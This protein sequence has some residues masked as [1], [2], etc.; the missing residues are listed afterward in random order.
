MAPLR[1][2]T[3]K[4][5]AQ[6]EARLAF[7][8]STP[9]KGFDRSRVKGLVARLVTV[10]A[11]SASSA[12]EIT[13]GAKLYQVVVDNET[14]GKLLLEKGKLRKRV[15][16]LPLNKLNSRVTDPSRVSK[17]KE[18][19]AAKGG[20][21][22]LALEL[23]GYDDEVLKAV[24][25]CFGATIICDRPDIAEA[26]AFHPQVRNKTVTLD[27]DSYDPSGTLTGG[28]KANLGETL[29]KVYTAYTTRTTYT[30]LVILDSPRNTSTSYCSVSRYNYYY[31]YY[32][33]SF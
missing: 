4:L 9:E 30:P 2:S 33:H 29:H 26:I 5:G 25:H 18:I 7:D 14:T 22:N 28:S 15:T 11:P 3:E 6:L 21:A 23:V 27:G 20:R 17:A 31:D 10:T 12:L 32:D 16:I 24:Q 19:A 8:F 13:A 1:D